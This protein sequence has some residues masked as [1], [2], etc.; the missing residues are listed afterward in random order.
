[1][2][3]N[4]L[5]FAF[6]LSLLITTLILWPIYRV[7]RLQK[8]SAQI[9]QNASKEAVLKTMGVPWKDEPCGAYLGGISSGCVEEFIYAHPYAPYLPQYWVIQFNSNHNVITSYPLLSP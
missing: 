6:G 3:R 5:Y 7:N 2:R 9:K 1:M 8:Q 4:P